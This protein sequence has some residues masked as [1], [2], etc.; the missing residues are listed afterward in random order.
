MMERRELLTLF[1]AGA[2][3]LMV[4]GTTRAD[5]EKDGKD[6]EKHHAHM[7]VM[8]ECALICN[9]VSAHC[10]KELAKQE[11]EHSELHAEIACATNDCQTFCVQAVTLMARHSKMAPHAH[12]ACADAC[13]DC[14][15][16]CEKSQDE[17]IKKCAEIC[18]ECERLC[19]E[20]CEKSAA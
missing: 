6:K 18:R 14:A 16:V 12:H 3:G 7:K 1:G 8:G 4:A 11:G 5:D 20:A 17:K 10:L 19:R 2:A 13:R 9:M 15:A